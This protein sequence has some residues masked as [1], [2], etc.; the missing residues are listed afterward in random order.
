M[1]QN[2]KKNHDKTKNTRAY[3]RYSGLAFQ[4]IATILV[5]VYLGRWI[6]QSMGNSTPW[7]TLLLALLAVVGSMY[8]LIKGLTKQ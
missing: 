2:P 5:F 6:D 8:R 3:L 4:L 7:F 1:Q